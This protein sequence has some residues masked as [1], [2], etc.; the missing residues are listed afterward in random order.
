MDDAAYDAGATGARGRKARETLADAVPVLS[1]DQ[2]ESALGRLREADYA[3]DDELVTRLL[4]RLG[5]TGGVR[6]RNR[7]AKWFDAET[8]GR[9]QRRADRQQRGT[10]AEQRKQYEMDM[11]YM[12]DALE[13]GTNGHYLK[14]GAPASVRGRKILMANRATQERWLSEEALRW[15]ADNGRPMPF[16]AWRY[17]NLGARDS[18]AVASWQN[19]S[20]G[21]FSEFG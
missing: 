6:R 9:D 13:A 2:A 18:R 21:W 10:L 17:A 15:F 4:D 8:S 20:E 7:A 5:E 3:G 14:K 12:L 11:A 19:R 1:A 16:D